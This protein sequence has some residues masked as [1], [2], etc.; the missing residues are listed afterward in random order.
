[1]GGSR[2]KAF[3]KIGRVV[4]EKDFEGQRKADMYFEASGKRENFLAD[5][6][7]VSDKGLDA[8]N[9][10]D[11]LLTELNRIAR[12]NGINPAL[13]SLFVGDGRQRQYRGGP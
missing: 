10:V 8:L 3:S 2:V 4:Y 11:D 1:M 13:F 7:T 5:I 12:Q 9:P 6:T